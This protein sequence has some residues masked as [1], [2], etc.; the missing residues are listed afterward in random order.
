M[1]DGFALGEAIQFPAMK[2]NLEERRGESL[3]VRRNAAGI[4]QTWEEVV[5]EESEKDPELRLIWDNLQAFRKDYAV[6][7]EWAFLPRPGT[8]RTAQV[9][10]Q[11]CGE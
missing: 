5:R 2:Q 4:P 8:V 6:W 3:L 10:A 7:N 9:T 1:L 11:L